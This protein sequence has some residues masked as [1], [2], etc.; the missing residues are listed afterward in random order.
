MNE[1]EG[2]GRKGTGGK[3]VNGNDRSRDSIY[4]NVTLDGDESA[5][6]PLERKRNPRQGMKLN[7]KGTGETQ[8]SVRAAKSNERKRSG[9]P[10][11]PKKLMTASAAV[12][13]SSCMHT[14][15]ALQRV[16]ITLS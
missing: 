12:S 9:T 7:V 4:S 15:C 14:W 10:E 6:W 16:M 3:S 5:A 8:R 13:L 2:R 1:R 11:G